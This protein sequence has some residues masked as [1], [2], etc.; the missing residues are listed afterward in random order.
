MYASYLWNVNR[1]CSPFD[2]IQPYW[3]ECGTYWGADS[4]FSPAE[5]QL[6]WP[7]IALIV[8]QWRAI[9]LTVMVLSKRR[10]LHR[11]KSPDQLQA[12]VHKDAQLPILS[13]RLLPF[14]WLVGLD[15]AWTPRRTRP[16]LALGPQAPQAPHTRG[17]VR[18]GRQAAHRAVHAKYYVVDSPGGILGNVD[19]KRCANQNPFTGHVIRSTL[20]KGAGI[21]GN[22]RLRACWSCSLS[23]RPFPCHLPFVVPIPPPYPFP[24]LYSS[25]LLPL[26]SVAYVES[27][28][29]LPL[30]PKTRHSSSPLPSPLA[31]PTVTSGSKSGHERGEIDTSRRGLRSRY[32]RILC[33]LPFFLLIP[34]PTHSLLLPSSLAYIESK[35]TSPAHSTPF[36]FSAS[37]SSRRSP[38]SPPG[39]SPATSGGEI[40][41]F[42][43]LDGTSGRVCLRLLGGGRRG[44]RGGGGHVLFLAL[45]TLYNRLAPGGLPNART[46]DCVLRSRVRAVGIT[47][48]RSSNHDKWS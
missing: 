19:L 18:R 22:S 20:D 47:L 3:E 25:F 28:L 40:D 21:I 4:L 39:P 26:S 41:S 10:I 23:Y 43:G 17:G 34:L 30:Q 46:C 6:M 24:P 35:L 15:L 13:S 1:L 48:A 14:V 5:F 8:V 32:L 16:S 33:R 42:R 38:P 27:R 9:L 2:D 11:P 29:T 31:H 44:E 37:L 45:G 7:G 12:S 36:P